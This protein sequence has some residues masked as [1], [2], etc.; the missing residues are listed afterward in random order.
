MKCDPEE[1]EVGKMAEVFV[2]TDENGDLFE[3][4]PTGKG[5]Q[6]QY[7]IS[8]KFGRFGIGQGAYVNKTTI[9]CLTPSV[10]DDPDSIWKEQVILSV[11]M[12]GQD[13]NDDSSEIQFTFIGNGSALVFWPYVIACLLIALLLI[14]LIV[15]CSALL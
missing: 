3:P 12:N 10:S 13:F 2:N 6:G 7:G 11:S 5:T 15:F 4:I 9:K 8:C 1:V 14:A